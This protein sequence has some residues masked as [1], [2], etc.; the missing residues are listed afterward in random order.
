MHLC[1]CTVACVN[2]ALS[3]TLIPAVAVLVKTCMRHGFFSSHICCKDMILQANPLLLL[4]LPLPLTVA[5]AQCMTTFLQHRLLQAQQ[6]FKPTPCCC[7]H[8][9]CHC[10]CRCHC[11]CC[12]HCRCHY[13]PHCCVCTGLTPPYKHYEEATDDYVNDWRWAVGATPWGPYSN[14]SGVSEL[15]QV[16]SLAALHVHLIGLLCSACDTVQLCVGAEQVVLLYCS[17]SSLSL[18]ML[19]PL[20]QALVLC[21]RDCTHVKCCCTSISI[22]GDPARIFSL[23][24]CLTGSWCAAHLTP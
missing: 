23:L 14:Y 10:R 16:G 1:A 17:A 7:C 11:R 9:C 22:L 2:A 5:A 24:L 13:C 21:C 6:A 4:S 3:E 12:C 8:C 15:M 20:L 18:V 19:F